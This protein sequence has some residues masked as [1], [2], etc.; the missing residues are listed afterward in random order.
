MFPYYMRA[1]IFPC[2][3]RQVQPQVLTFIFTHFY[4][5]MSVLQ[6]PW[7]ERMHKISMDRQRVVCFQLSPVGAYGP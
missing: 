3:W 1:F 5:S 6:A 4:G 7:D 2:T